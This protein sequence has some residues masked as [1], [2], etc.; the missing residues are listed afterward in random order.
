MQR[1][2][3]AT[4]SEVT[5]QFASMT[6]IPS[7]SQAKSGY[8]KLRWVKL[9][10]VMLRY[11]SVPKVKWSKAKS[12]AVKWRFKVT[13]TE[14]LHVTLTRLAYVLVSYVKLRCVNTFCLDDWLHHVQREPT[15]SSCF[16]YSLTAN[17][18]PPTS[19]LYLLKPQEI[20]NNKSFNR[21]SKVPEKVTQNKAN[22]SIWFPQSWKCFRTIICEIKVPYLVWCLVCCLVCCCP[23]VACT[24]FA[25]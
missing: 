22:I 3:D 8:V 23:R 13:V 25:A 5:T 24:V 10:Y 7:T 21:E 4:F 6:F 18:V 17:H 9:D 19:D 2:G 14:P 1:G 20:K 11:A 16:D 12:G 15:G